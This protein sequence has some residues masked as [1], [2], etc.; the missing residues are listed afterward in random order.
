[1]SE[2][3]KRVLE[4]L[5]QG[6]ITSDEAEQLLEKLEA[7]RADDEHSNG[8][9]TAGVPRYLRIL[10]GDADGDKVN[11]RIPLALVRTGIKLST[12][13]PSKV[14][15]KMKEKGIDLSPLSELQ[16]EELM[17]ALEE[18]SVDVDSPDGDSVRIFC[19]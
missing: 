19:E 3:R 18:L 10:M 12:M 4:M 13:V 6:K 5:A 15:E 16:D 9:R 17:K 1:M 2:E 8:A 11:I 14:S 7:S